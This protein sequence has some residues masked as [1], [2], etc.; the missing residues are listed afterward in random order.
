M[1][2]KIP[3]TKWRDNPKNEENIYAIICLIRDLYLESV[4]Y[5]I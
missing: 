4:K 3:S 2:Q 5:T 1:P